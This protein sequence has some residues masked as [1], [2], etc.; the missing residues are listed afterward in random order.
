MRIRKASVVGTQKGGDWHRED[1][2][3]MANLD[4]VC[5]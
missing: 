2:G 3:D 4:A 5:G 1:G